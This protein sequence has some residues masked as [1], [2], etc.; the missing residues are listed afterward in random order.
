MNYFI[1]VH[2]GQARISC[3]F[4]E[5]GRHLMQ[6]RDR[7]GIRQGELA[8]R[9]SL[10]PAVLSRIESGERLVTPQEV[11]DILAQIDTPEA[12]EL[13]TALQ[14]VWQVLTRPTLDHPHQPLLWA[15]E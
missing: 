11:Q 3:D 10:S 9:V 7:A 4:A 15:A 1:G 14:R 13:S 12:K 5:I 2:H 6:V 8:K